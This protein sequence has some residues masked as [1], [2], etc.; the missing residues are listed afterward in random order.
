[1]TTPCYCTNLRL[2]AR[3]LSAIYDRAL[4]PF[5]INIAQYFLLRTIRNKQPVS[6]TEVGLQTELDRSTVG[7]NVRVLERMGLVQTRRSETDQ[8][9]AQ[10][11]LSNAGTALMRDAEPVWEGCQHRFVRRLGRDQVDALSALLEA[12]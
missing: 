6:L 5:G 4:E 7:R 2:A 3:K 12:I 10:V 8:R 9:E 1:M 11:S